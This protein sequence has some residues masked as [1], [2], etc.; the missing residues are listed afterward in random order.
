MLNF[1]NDAQAAAAAGPDA[2]GGGIST[3]IFLVV[4][5]FI[6]YFLFIRPQ[7]K[8]VKDHRNLVE[9]LAKG[10]EVV[11]VGGMLGRINNVGDNFVQLEIADGIEVKVQKSSVVASMPKGTVKSD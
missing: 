3:L 7:N 2:A 1:I 10:D 5:F 9:N 8:R 4:F 6:F 11:T